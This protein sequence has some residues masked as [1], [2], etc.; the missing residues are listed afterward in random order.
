VDIKELSKEIHA[1]FDRVSTR[2]AALN[3]EREQLEAEHESLLKLALLYD[4]MKYDSITDEINVTEKI[5]KEPRVRPQKGE[6]QYD[7]P[8]EIIFKTAGTSL[9]INK[10]RQDLEDLTNKEITYKNVVAIIK[11]Q[12]DKGHIERTGY[13]VYGWVNRE[14]ENECEE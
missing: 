10:I 14:E 11:Q 9:P 3:K 13:G 1:R 2:L 8:L 12:I 4:N 7:E 5:L 6:S